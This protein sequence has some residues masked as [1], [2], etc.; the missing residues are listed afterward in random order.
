MAWIT[1][2]TGTL[3]NP[4]SLLIFALGIS[5]VHVII[6]Q[7]QQGLNRLVYDHTSASRS[8]LAVHA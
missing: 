5:Y 8:V 1:G 3:Q 4:S 7:P 6:L 2:A